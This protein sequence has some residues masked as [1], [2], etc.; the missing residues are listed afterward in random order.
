MCVVFA[1]AFLLFY[2]HFLF[3]F[4]AGSPAV[5]LSVSI[6]HDLASVFTAFLVHVSIQCLLNIKILVIYL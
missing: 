1:T 4:S 2:F 3:K 5:C 6:M